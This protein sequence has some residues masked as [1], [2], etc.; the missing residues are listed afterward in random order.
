MNWTLG[1]VSTAVYTVCFVVVGLL[2]LNGH[3]GS[4]DLTSLIGWILTGWLAC[5][6]TIIVLLVSGTVRWL[7]M[8][9]T[10][11]TGS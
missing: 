9:C 8:T 7:F 4:V 6:T 11:Q 5:Y 10:G 2:A 3:I 1:K